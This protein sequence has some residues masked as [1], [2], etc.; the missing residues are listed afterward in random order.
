MSRVFG[1]LSLLALLAVV[2]SV[3]GQV[4]PPPAKL[5][6]DRI[7]T[8]QTPTTITVT[9]FFSNGRAL[10]L[11]VPDGGNIVQAASV[12]AP[13]G[14]L[15]DTADAT[16][17]LTLKPGPIPGP[18]T[19]AKPAV[20]VSA[21]AIQT[22]TADIPAAIEPVKAAVAVILADDGKAAGSAVLVAQDRMVA[23]AAVV[24]AAKTLRV[25]FPGGAELPGTII[26][27][28]PKTGLALLQVVSGKKAALK[29]GTAAVGERVYAISS[30][31]G[32]GESVRAGSVTDLNATAKD[33]TGLLGISIAV[34]PANS[35][36]ALVNAQGSL[37][38]IA[39]TWPDSEGNF[40][41]PAAAVTAMLAAQP[42]GE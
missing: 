23:S 39:C 6:I 28:D 19:S 25:R 16:S 41:V 15:S 29:A 9:I 40:A 10:V 26:S 27:S 31:Y 17:T 5:S 24:G 3:G 2:L 32:S 22:K 14:K 4:P 8:D 33:K 1:A 42:V 35:S 12:A 38:G 30:P 13:T 21:T 34:E 7:A 11:Y 37:V 36:S 18:A 20:K